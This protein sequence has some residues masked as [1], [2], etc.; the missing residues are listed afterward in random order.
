MTHLRLSHLHWGG[1]RWRLHRREVG[2]GGQRGGE[3]G[4]LGRGSGG[5]GSG[6]RIL[7]GQ[8]LDDDD[9]VGVNIS[10]AKIGNVILVVSGSASRLHRM[11]GQ[12]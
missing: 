10:R 8:D 3:A 7:G 12:M 6:P 9:D 4:V 11:T 5:R 1:G 2:G